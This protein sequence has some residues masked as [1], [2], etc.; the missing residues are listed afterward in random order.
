MSITTPSL[1][2]PK[3]SPTPKPVPSS[4]DDVNFALPRGSDP[5]NAEAMNK[6]A[7][8]MVSDA[9]LRRVLL[10]HNYF[11]NYKSGSL[12]AKSIGNTAVFWFDLSRLRNV[13]LNGHT[14][15]ASTAMEVYRATRDVQANSDIEGNYHYETR[16]LGP[17]RN[18]ALFDELEVPSSRPL[19]ETA[20]TSVHGEDPTIHSEVAAK[21]RMKIALIEIFIS[22]KLVPDTPAG[23]TEA[24]QSAENLMQDGNFFIGAASL[25]G[26]CLDICNTVTKP[27]RK[28]AATTYFGKV[29]SEDSTN[30]KLVT[31]TILPLT[32]DKLTAEKKAA[33]SNAPSQQWDMACPDGAFST[34]QVREHELTAALTALPLTSPCPPEKVGGL[35]KALGSS[36]LGG[37]DF[38]TVEMRYM[39]D[40]P[41]AGGVQYA[42]SGKAAA[43]GLTQDFDSGLDAVTNSAADLRTWLVLKPQKFWVNLN[44]DEPD[45][46]ID[47]QL[48][49]TNAG[50]ALLEADWE[51]KRTSGKL[52]DPKTD[53]GKRYWDSLAGNCYTSRMWIIPG[54]VEVREDGDSLYV[55]EAKLDVKAQAMHISNTGKYSCNADSQT[56]ARNERMEQ[57]MLVPKIVKAVNTSP[58]YAPLR[59]AFLARVIAQWIRKRHQDGHRTSFDRL[60]DS[61]NLGPAVLDGDWRPKQVYDQYVHSIKDGE[62]TYTQVTDQGGTRYKHTMVYGGVDFSKLDTKPISAAQMKEQ[63]P[64]LPET[65]K[66]SLKHPSS[67]PDGMI[68]LGETAA[69]PKVGLM[70]RTTDTVRSFVTGKTGLLILVLGALGVLVFGMRGGTRRK[71]RTS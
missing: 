19:L 62:F 50:R 59:R 48:G 8:K 51:M 7:E 36:D 55:L 58:E 65:A 29:R 69:T 57:K 5:Q 20:I 39:S 21:R 37:V 24:S 60:I 27:A 46:I 2:A 22:N 15:P 31:A 26:F 13:K 25:Y 11:R 33:A 70:T 61:G 30:C 53:F 12:S 18:Q 71:R 1:A 14:Y 42:F 64:K 40:D 41:E 56:I 17:D 67:T 28:R 23:V 16:L 32:A 54:D 3:P 34:R 10:R 43:P 49:K 47:P 38:S 63:H 45:R 35:A 9:M 68:W 52:V 6:G 4:Q 66:A 44:P